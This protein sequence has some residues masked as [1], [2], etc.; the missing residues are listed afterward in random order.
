MPAGFFDNL[1]RTTRRSP[2]EEA[3]FQ[4]LCDPPEA[5]LTATSPL[6]PTSASPPPPKAAGPET[7]SKTKAEGQA[8]TGSAEKDRRTETSLPRK[9]GSSTLA[10]AQR[11]QSLGLL[12]YV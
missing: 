7:A 12:G 1:R 3:L 11:A 5:A 10:P 4:E 2:R 8:R 9:R 6:P